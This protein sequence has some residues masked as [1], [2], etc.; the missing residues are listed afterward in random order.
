[1]TGDQQIWQSWAR[2]IHQWGLANLVA[3][4]LESAGPLAVLGAQI[5]YI[6]QPILQ[7]VTR[8]GHLDAL[9]S[10]LE[11]PQHTRTFLNQLE[12]EHSP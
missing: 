5:V 12:G 4:F 11:D 2:T 8:P 9:A 3:A 10:L 6:S 1:M 7:P